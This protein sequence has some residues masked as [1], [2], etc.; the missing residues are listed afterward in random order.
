MASANSCC[1][2]MQ[3]WV[4]MTVG[5]LVGDTVGEPVGLGELVGAEVDGAAVVGAIELGT[6]L[7]V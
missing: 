2:L 3:A 1:D 5:V 7:G 4:G 6:L